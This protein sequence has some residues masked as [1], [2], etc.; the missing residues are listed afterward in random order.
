MLNFT[1]PA[2]LHFG[3]LCRG[4]TSV[5]LPFVQDRLDAL[6]AKHPNFKIHYIVDKSDNKAWKGR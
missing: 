3:P 1:G 2:L 4:I 5:C 6:A